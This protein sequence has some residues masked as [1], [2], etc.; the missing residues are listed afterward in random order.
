M[1]AARAPSREFATRKCERGSGADIGL[2]VRPS[3]G[4]SQDDRLQDVV[5]TLDQVPLW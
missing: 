4:T 2:G 3:S 1:N 5:V